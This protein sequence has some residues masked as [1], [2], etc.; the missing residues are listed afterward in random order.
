MFSQRSALTSILL[1]ALAA[2]PRLAAPHAALLGAQVSFGLFPVLG[3]VAFS[4][5]LASNLRLSPVVVSFVAG[6]IV[7]LRSLRSAHE[8]CD[9]HGDVATTSLI[10]VWIDESERRQWFLG[11]TIRES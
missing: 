5:G 6:L 11:E 2:A 1:L 8:V 10:E 9:S 3:T 7:G 4:A